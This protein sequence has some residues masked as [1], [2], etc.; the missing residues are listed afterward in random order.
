MEK[1]VIIS[2][3]SMDISKETRLEYGI[4]YPVCG[5]II[6]SDGRVEDSDAEWDKYTPEQYFNEE[7]KKGIKTSLPNQY[8]IVSKLEPYFQNG[9]DI[10][11]IVLSTGIS[12]TYSA[13]VTAGQELMEKYPDRKILVVD[14]LRYSSGVGL[15]CL[16]ASELRAQGK[17]IQETY[18]WVNNARLSVHQCGVL[19]DLHFLARN[20]KI[21]GFKAFMGT[22]VGVKPIADFSNQT[23]QPFPLG[24]VR[25][26]KK[27]YKLIGQYIQATIGDASDKIIVVES[28]LRDEQ[29]TELE[30]IVKE[31]IKPRKVIRTRCGMTNGSA[32]GPG[33]ATVFYV[34][35]KEL[36][37]NL[38]EESKI[39]KDIVATL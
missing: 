30:K 1:F 3:S 39:F 38:Q 4:E 31:Q 24:N 26:Y 13:F 36:T 29:A 27:A 16:Y 34:G 2:D 28:S 19:D 33:L 5:K 11:A 14:S 18:D 7:V 25:G 6:F 9:Q 12:G 10:L 8:E 21:T 17:S 22:M 32:I 15:L 35:E 20:G 37:E 23:G